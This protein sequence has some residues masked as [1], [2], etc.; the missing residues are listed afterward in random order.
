[1]RNESGGGYKG[2]REGAVG[3]L[4]GSECVGERELNAGG[5]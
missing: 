5:L 1:M 2:K 4:G 3:K